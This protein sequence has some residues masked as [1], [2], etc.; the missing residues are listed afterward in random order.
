[1]KLEW[2]TQR[3]AGAQW[4]EAANLPLWKCGLYPRGVQW[5]M[6]I[7]PRPPHCDRGRYLLMLDAPIDHQ[8][9]FPRYYFDLNVAKSEAE[10]WVNVRA[11]LR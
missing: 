8:E 5:K 6:W 9:G 11:E 3:E 7:A 1:M 10:A 4:L 2:I